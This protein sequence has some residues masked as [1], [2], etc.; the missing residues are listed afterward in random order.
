M[1]KKKKP[2][3]SKPG[4]K[5][6]PTQAKD[7]RGRPQFFDDAIKKAEFVAYLNSGISKADACKLVGCARRTIMYAVDRDA[8]FRAAIDKAETSG[9]AVAAGC[10]VKHSATNPQ[11]ALQLLARKRPN[12]WAYRKPDVV[13]RQQFKALIDQL[14]A[15]LINEVPAEYHPKINAAIN[16]LLVGVIG[17]PTAEE[18][19]DG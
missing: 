7:P 17:G 11:I 12:E 4:R 2:T 6:Q 14:I 5:K 3:A 13:S 8:D 1:G 15:T 10:V 19:E 16:N 18:P 9:I